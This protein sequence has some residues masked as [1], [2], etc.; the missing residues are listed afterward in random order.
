MFYLISLR[1][2]LCTRWFIV[3]YRYKVNF[4]TRLTLHGFL[5]FFFFPHTN[6]NKIINCYNKSSCGRT[7][8]IYELPKFDVTVETTVDKHVRF[9]QIERTP[10]V[11]KLRSQYVF[12][13]FRIF[14]YSFNALLQVYTY[15]YFFSLGPKT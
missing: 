8:K 11:Y 12:Q 5:L 9:V 4:F 13:E 6:K 10:N 1:I 15:L 2:V 3:A 14:I 7:I